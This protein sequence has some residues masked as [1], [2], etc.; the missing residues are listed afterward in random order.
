M[1]DGCDNEDFVARVSPARRKRSA[2]GGRGWRGGFHNALLHTRPARGS[3]ET[4]P[5]YFLYHNGSFLSFYLVVSNIILLALTF[6]VMF[7]DARKK[8]N[9]MNYFIR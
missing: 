5:A 4:L 1:V 9:G 3:P 8:H 7:Y 6:G 2:C